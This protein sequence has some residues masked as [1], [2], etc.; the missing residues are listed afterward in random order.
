MLKILVIED[1]IRISENI[2]EILEAENFQVL[3]AADG[4]IGV[5]L[6]REYQPDLIICDIMMPKLDGYGVLTELQKDVDTALIPFIFLTALAEQK[7]FRQGM[8]LGADD[9]L[10][11]PCSPED[12]LSAIATRLEKQAN[13]TQ[14]QI[15]HLSD[16][17]KA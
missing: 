6:A 11:K 14:Q 17:P 10:T 5:Q 8:N 16:N 13:Y 9:Y 2:L 3:A 1:N 15:Q 12:I 4:E 7:D